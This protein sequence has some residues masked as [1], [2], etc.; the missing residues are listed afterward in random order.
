M[1]LPDVSDIDPMRRSLYAVLFKC[2]RQR[3]A[4][5]DGA[6]GIDESK[7]RRPRP[8]QGNAEESLHIE[9]ENFL[10]S[11][12]INLLPGRAD[13]CGPAWLHGSSDQ[14]SG[15]QGRDRQGRSA[16]YC[17]WRP[18]GNTSTAARSAPSPVESSKVGM[19]TT[20]PIL[21]GMVSGFDTR[22]VPSSATAA[23]IRLPFNAAARLSGCDS[24]SKRATV[25][26]LF[27]EP[28]AGGGPHST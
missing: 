26:F 28:V 12:G 16:G 27:T 4:D 3:V 17:R 21:P 22:T 18:F 6:F 11:P 25:E 9:F 20:V 5:F 15:R 24:N 1:S 2:R 14:F 10:S 19:T 8:A 7:Y 13:G 23:E